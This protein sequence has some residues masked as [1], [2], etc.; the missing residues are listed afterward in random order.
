MDYH[1]LRDFM[2]AINGPFN[3]WTVSLAN[4]LQFVDRRGAHFQRIFPYGRVILLTEDFMTRE[5]QAT[6]IILAWFQ[7]LSQK[8]F[9]GSWKLM[10][11]PNV[12]DWLL[13]QQDRADKIKSDR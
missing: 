1:T 5:S 8:K 3:L 13:T 9:P 2:K 4:P 7:E 11:R 6:V 10:L 12:L